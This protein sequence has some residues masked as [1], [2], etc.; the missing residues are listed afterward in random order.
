MAIV[1]LHAA[2]VA[3]H[4]L[5][6]NGMH[7]Y[8][9]LWQNAYIMMVIVALPLL[10]GLLL[11]WRARA[12]F[13][14]LFYSM[15]GSLLFGGYYHFIAPGP[16]NVSSLGVHAWAFPFQVSAVLLAVTEVAGAVV[17]VAGLRAKRRLER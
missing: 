3:V 16:D 11:W 13:F 5:S 7:I 17:A 4:S 8:M 12:G 1:A 6:H 10:S 14:L 15:L 2:V 9:A